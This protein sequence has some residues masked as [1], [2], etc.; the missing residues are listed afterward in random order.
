MRSVFWYL[1]EPTYVALEGVLDKL[2]L[3][4]TLTEK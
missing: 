2:D 4:L 1:I 3:E